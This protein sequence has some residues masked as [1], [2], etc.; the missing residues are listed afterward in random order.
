MKDARNQV[1]QRRFFIPS[2]ESI[3][4]LFPLVLPSPRPV[5]NATVIFVG[6]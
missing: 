5:I 6:I 3:D 4:T 2:I 1:E